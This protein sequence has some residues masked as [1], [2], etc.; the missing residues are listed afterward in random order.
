MRLLKKA[1]IQDIMKEGRENATVHYKEIELYTSWEDI[2]SFD[3]IKIENLAKK[4]NENNAI[5]SAIHCP[6][7]LIPT[8]SDKNSERSTNYLSICEAIKYEDSREKL[9]QLIKFAESIYLKQWGIKKEKDD[10]EKIEEN[11]EDK[12][13]ISE[14]VKNK[15]DKLLLIIHSGCEIGCQKNNENKNGKC[16]IPKK[17]KDKYFQSIIKNDYIKIVIEN[18]TPYLDNNDINFIKGQNCGWSITD[19]NQWNCFELAKILGVGVCVDICHIFATHNIINGNVDYS[20]ALSD[21][22]KYIKDKKIESLISLFHISNYGE[23]G[24]HGLQFNDTDADN[25]LLEQIRKFCFEI[26]PTALV[27]LEV[28]D[29]QDYE[30]ACRNFDRLMLKLSERHTSGLFGDILN[31]DNNKNLKQYFDDL[32]Y[33]YAS[34]G[35]DI[36]EIRERALRIKKYILTNTYITQE[37][38]Q[39]NHPFNFSKDL[40]IFDTAIFR[41]QAYIY[42]TRFCNL[43]MFLANYYNMNSII[44]EKNIAEDFALSLK[45]FMFNDDVKQIEYTGVAFRFNVDW[46][47]QEDTFFRFYDGIIKSKFNFNKESNEAPMQYIINE[48]RQHIQGDCSL[49]SCGRNFGVCLFKYWQPLTEENSWTVRVYD[50]TPINFIDYKNK[51][52][53][54]PAFMQLIGNEN[55]DFNEVSNFSFDMSRFHKGRGKD[56][57]S[58]KN[59]SSLFSLFRY[60]NDT[61]SSIERTGSIM[62]G[63]IVFLELSDKKYV[64]LSDKN[65]SKFAFSTYS[66][67][68]LLKSYLKYISSKEYKVEDIMEEVVKNLDNLIIN[69]QE[70]EILSK[71]IR[72]EGE[73]GNVKKLLSKI[74]KKESNTKEEL[75]SFSPYKLESEE[76]NKLFWKIEGKLWRGDK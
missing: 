62:D 34:D 11:N 13:N 57:S 21:Y 2:E 64:E 10:K 48:I 36:F 51:R 29:G 71:L 4:L 39:I 18:I 68:V 56:N 20:K 7:S 55:I 24:V 67:I 37:S 40:D 16:E 38:S 74:S 70:N 53:S 65:Y 44:D 1:S 14:K 42:Y 26:A 15:Y 63:E 43:G 31:N 25:E 58:E 52:Y 72:N 61:I 12:L 19:E 6:E 28:S 59:A 17:G 27:T 22:L 41:M 35:K 75:L 30:K 50:K 46:L 5:I 60:Y 76:I 69:S 33:V 73:L 9:N 66:I 49:F 23:N 47:P 32:Y 3:E 8:S 54:I 45:Y